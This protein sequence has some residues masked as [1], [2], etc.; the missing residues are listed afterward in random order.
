MDDEASSRREYLAAVAAGGYAGLAGCTGTR[1]G[2]A[3]T[4]T[5]AARETD[6]TTATTGSA[7]SAPADRSGGTLAV[8]Q[9][10]VAGEGYDPHQVTRGFYDQYAFY[11][12]L[13]RYETTEGGPV[14]EPHLAREWTVASPT[15]YE[16]ALHDGIE[17]HDG[18]T[19]DAEVVQ[20][21]F[22][23]MGREFSTLRSTFA[24]VDA[25][26]VLDD[27]RFAVE[28]S[29]P[30]GP[31]LDALAAN[32]YMVSREAAEEHG[33]TGFPQNPVGTGP[34]KHGSHSESRTVLVRNESYFREDGVPYLEEVTVEAIPE[35]QTRVSALRTGDVQLLLTAPASHLEQLRGDGS[36]VVQSALGNAQT[37]DFI[38]Y[39]SATG[40]F[41]DRRV[42]R[43]VNYAIDSEEIRSF[44]ARAEPLDGPLPVSSWGSNPDATAYP[45]D[46]E[47][48]QTLLDE[49]G[50]PDLE[51]TAYVRPNRPS[52]TQ[53]A[54]LV[55]SQLAEIGVTMTIETLTTQSLLAKL[56]NREYDA[57][58]LRWGGLGS[59]DPGVQLRT[60]FHSE[61]SFSFTFNVQDD[62]IDRLV[63]EGNRL[64][65]R[66]ERAPKFR[67]AEQLLLD[68][69]VG[70]FS[71]RL[72]SFLAHRASV[73]DVAVE[74]TGFHPRLDRVWLPEAER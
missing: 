33:P 13:V 17:F 32:S 72:A 39:N 38:G 35:S 10:E 54:E 66:A 20:Y 6:T 64:V 45:H 74:P 27:L 73:N 34:W 60:L 71:L 42:R 37:I 67:R 63:D 14:V 49:A 68:G 18:T 36:I 44:L 21:N 25:V 53:W 29:R 11:D 50:R 61:G 26:E 12:T 30:S 43:A 31:F 28:L 69:A 5:A 55:K 56:Q 47:R 40:P 58:F 62:E 70:N 2:D 1:D 65:D 24:V 46:P 59:L 23:R 9:A 41:S 57:H 8:G 7:E 52:K 22:D 16:F 4:E 19:L 3:S 51:F 15:R 48:A